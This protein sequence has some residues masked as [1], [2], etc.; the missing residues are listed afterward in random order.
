M[1]DTWFG[2]WLN[3]HLVRHRGMGF[4]APESDDGRVI[5]STWLRVLKLRGIHEESLAEDAS[6][7]L[8][9]ENVKFPRDHFPRLVELAIEI[10]RDRAAQ[11]PTGRDSA[12]LDGAKFNSKACPHCS[13]EGL[14]TIRWIQPRED[15][16]EGTA[17]AYCLCEAG[18]KIREMHKEDHHRRIPLL[19]DVLSGRYH[20]FIP[21]ATGDVFDRSEV[22]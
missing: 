9:A 20:Q 16:D 22:A 18:R 11:S 12:T 10:L 2:T 14:A 3:R 21:F 17:T 7:R 13:G 5:Y 19:R 4:P 6:E 8:M 15:I 1:V